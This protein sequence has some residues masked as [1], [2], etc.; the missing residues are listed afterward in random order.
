MP[1]KVRKCKCKDSNGNDGSYIITKNNNFKKIS[2]H[3]SK[4][5]AISSIR[6]KH[7]NENLQIFIREALKDMLHEYSKKINSVAGSQPEE[8]YE[9]FWTE[10]DKSK[11]DIKS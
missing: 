2:C 6:A 11:I 5:K 3:S 10:F 1:Y 7:A 4:K 8:S 9:Y